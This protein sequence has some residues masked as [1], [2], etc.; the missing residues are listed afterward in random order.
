M[1]SCFLDT[2]DRSGG[3]GRGGGG[4][5]RRLPVREGVAGRG[6]AQGGR[7]G[8][9]RPHPAAQRA[10]HLAR[11]AQEAHQHHAQLQHRRALHLAA[12]ERPSPPPPS[13]FAPPLSGCS[14]AACPQVN[15]PLLRLLH[16]IANMYQNVKDT[17]VEL[18][19]QTK[20]SNRRNKHTSS[21]GECRPAA[22][23]PRPSPARSLTRRPVS[24]FR[25]NLVSVSSLDKDTQY[26][27]LDSKWDAAGEAASLPP[28]A[29]T[30]A[31]AAA[32]APPA[33][34]RPRPQSFAQKLRST[35]KSV[36]GKLGECSHVR[37]QE[38]VYIVVGTHI[39]P[40]TCPRSF[41]SQATAL[42]RRAAA[43]PSRARRRQAPAPR[44]RPARPRR[45]RLRPT[46]PI[47]SRRAA[48][49]PCTC[50]WTCTPTCPTPRPSRTGES[51]RR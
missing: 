4:G 51:P 30:P 48:G 28:P 19:S 33:A 2:N 22:S 17:Q 40:L 5:R 14:R 25:E 1:F 18:R 16:Q 41:S 20:T 38:T 11:P 10:L 26:S 36:K 45:R 47:I 29:A 46:R 7:R 50:C 3:G 8:R 21:S 23:P 49:A 12:G 37:P 35:G 39:R 6:P 24:D 32:P 42:C 15:M 43:R 44:P 27:T 31:P 9:G 13:P 34:A